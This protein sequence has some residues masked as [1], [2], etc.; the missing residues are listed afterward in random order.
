MSMRGGEISCLKQRFSPLAMGLLTSKAGR[1]WLP[2]GGH[3]PSDH[4]VA[5]P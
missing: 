3:S 1:S 2:K 5:L 4:D